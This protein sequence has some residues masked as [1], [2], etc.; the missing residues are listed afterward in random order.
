[1]K[2]TYRLAACGFAILAAL[3]ATTRFTTSNDSHADEPAESRIFELRTYTTNPGKLPALHARFRDHTM[4][5]FE[6]HGMKNVAYWTPSDEKLAD[7]TLIYI[8]SHASPE[9][10][11]ASWKG[12][13][14]DPQWKEAYAESIADGKL[15][16]KVESV[17]M[18][19]TDFSPMKK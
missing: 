14:S 16:K 12:F 2:S 4:K 8:V 7:N 17:Y 19:P 3:V 18:T 6:K 11:K 10:A 9:A 1:M 15:V 13:I 5:L